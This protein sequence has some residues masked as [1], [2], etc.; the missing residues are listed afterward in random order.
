[1]ERDSF[2]NTNH[3]N[4]SGGNTT[5]DDD[6]ED[7]PDIGGYTNSSLDREEKFKMVHKRWEE[8]YDYEGSKRLTDARRG[9]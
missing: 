7:V 5:M 3:L 1:M 2:Y 4:D 9:T 6:S 8:L